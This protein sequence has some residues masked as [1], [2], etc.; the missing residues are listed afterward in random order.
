MAFLRDH[1]REHGAKAQQVRSK[2]GSGIQS[3]VSKLNRFILHGGMAEVDVLMFQK[4]R[5]TD[6][7]EECKHL[8]GLAV[9]VETGMDCRTSD[10]RIVGGTYL[11]G[12]AKLRINICS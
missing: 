7:L 6:E 4:R 2:T 1:C 9:I 11:L 5:P 10:S 12:Y 8:Y 3:E